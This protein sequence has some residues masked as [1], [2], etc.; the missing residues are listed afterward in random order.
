MRFSFCTFSSANSCQERS[1]R[2]AFSLVELVVSLGIV[3]VL[4]AI[5][6]PAVQHARESSRRME[7]ESRFKQILL[8]V[9]NFESAFGEIPTAAFSSR[10]DAENYDSDVGPLGRILSFVGEAPR[11]NHWK[12]TV[13]ISTRGVDESLRSS[14]ST[15][16][17]PSAP[18]TSTVHDIAVRFGGEAFP[19]RSRE[20]CDV[21]FNGG[22]GIII[23]GRL[24]ENTNGSFPIRLGEYSPRK[25]FRDV[26]D[27]LSNTLACWES[28]GPHL[29][30]PFDRERLLDF[31]GDAGRRF[32]LYAPEQEGSRFVSSTQASSKSYLYSWTGMRTGLMYAYDE[33]GRNGAPGRGVYERCINFANAFSTPYSYHPGL[34][35]VGFMDGSVRTKSESTDATLLMQLSMQADR[36]KWSYS[37]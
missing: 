24:S 3:G 20:V 9:H 23:G 28:A 7:C 8:G 1:K 2:S 12:Q 18:G 5:S 25:R 17:C 15:Y 32:T 13:R 16:L 31:D 22:A 6:I 36:D 29:V 26:Q 33:Q 19:G 34:C 30:F 10:P 14:P 35:V 27:G 37:W 4:L 11:A 21:A